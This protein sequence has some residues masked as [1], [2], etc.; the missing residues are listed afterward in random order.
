[1]KVR[2][3]LTQPERCGAAS[4]QELQVFSV[5]VGLADLGDFL[6]GLE[7]E[8]LV[9]TGRRLDTVRVEVPLLA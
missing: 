7:N 3:V 4:L 5:R 8:T 1:M 6:L 9:A 2:N